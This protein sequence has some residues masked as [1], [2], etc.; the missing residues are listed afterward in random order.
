MRHYRLAGVV[1]ACFLIAGCDDSKFADVSGTVRLDGEPIFEGSITFLP[2]DGQSQTAGGTIKDGKY[3]VSV[4]VGQMKVSISYPKVSGSKKLYDTPD[5]PIG[6]LYKES[7][8][9]RYNE[10]TELVLEVKPGKN[11][12]DWELTSKKK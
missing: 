3:S 4:P 1:M 2:V 5:S 6:Y 11:T 8:P 7:V 9:A 10:Q 12:K